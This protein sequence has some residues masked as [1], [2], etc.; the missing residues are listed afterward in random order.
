MIRD[1]IKKFIPKKVLLWR[2][3]MRGRFF[4]WLVANRVLKFFFIGIVRIIAKLNYDG[5]IK[6][7]SRCNLARTG[8]IFKD[9][10]AQIAFYAVID[11]EVRRDPKSFEKFKNLLFKD[12]SATNWSKGIEKHD[13]FYLK[14][15]NTS[16]LT[17]IIALITTSPK[18]DWKLLDMGCGTGNCVRILQNAIAGKFA[19]I[20]GIDFSKDAIDYARSRF[21]ANHH[22]FIANDMLKWLEESPAYADWQYDIAFS[23]LVF[24]LFDEDY[25][26]KMFRLMK[27]KKISR[28]IYISDSYC[29]RKT[30]L[31]ISPAS[32]YSPMGYYRFDHNHKKILASLGYVNARILADHRAATGLVFAAADAV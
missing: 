7:Y 6:F 3:E 27:E 28:S 20:D 31:S 15:G 14:D 13:D 11:P 16:C 1:R 30:D 8:S 22:R 24:Q 23:H 17:P 29:N 12:S 21:N 10:F 25:I 2:A 18:K 19:A 32:V 26:V 4:R 5:V 9:Y